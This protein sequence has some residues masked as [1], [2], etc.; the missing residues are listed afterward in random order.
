MREGYSTYGGMAGR[1]LEALAVGYLEGSDDNYLK[2]R[3]DHSTYLGEQL[4]KE[5]VP[6]C[7][8]VGGHGVWIDSL[9]FAPHIPREEYPGL[10][11]TTAMY[12]EGGIRAC[13]LGSLAFSIRDEDTGEIISLPEVD[14][15]RM[16][17]PRRVYSYKH[18]DY[19]AAVIGEIYRNREKLGGYKVEKYPYIKYRTVFL[20]EMAPINE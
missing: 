9:K 4:K 11:I 1:D 12:I 13:E 19:T 16:A 2:Y 14:L 20:G 17:I 5:G 15:V 10:A 18:L 3:I 7:T 6:I 8:P